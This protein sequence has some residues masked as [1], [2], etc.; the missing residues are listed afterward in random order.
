MAPW[1]AD[2]END[3][4]A[5]EPIAGGDAPAPGPSPDAP[6]EGG[7]ADTAPADT[8]SADAPNVDD[9]APQVAA[10]DDGE[11]RLDLDGYEGPIDV[12]LTL[13]REQKVDLKKISIL[14]LADQYLSFINH[15]RKLRLELAADYLVMAA[16]LAYLKS[17]LLLPEP[18]ADGEPTGVELAAALAFQL[19][20]LEAMQKAGQSLLNLPQLGRD[21]FTRGAP[22]PLKIVDIPVYELTLYE[23]LKAY[24]THPGRRREG[25]LQIQPLNLFSMD[26]ALKRIGDMLGHTLDWTVLQNFLPDGLLKPLQRRAAVAA[27]FA[28]SLE[29]A[30]SG[31]INIRQD[32]L[33]GPIYMKRAE[34][35]ADT[36]PNE[37]TPS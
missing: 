20:R 1:I 10:N 35:R 25:M 7:E 18:P 6:V 31:I 33:F 4:P 30:R 34:P 26:D 14:E 9:V 16:W 8:P 37:A 3:A 23:L 5:G 2:D 17:R 19:Q 12:L 11:L 21:V 22:E 24:G 15:A 29:L 36:S 32:G 28:A 13:A 27:T